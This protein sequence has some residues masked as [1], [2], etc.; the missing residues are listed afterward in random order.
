MRKDMKKISAIL[1]LLIGA[2][3]LSFAQ[4]DFLTTNEVDQVRDTQ[5]PNARL[6]LYVLFA[7]Q[8]MDQFQQLLKKDKKG[9]S[10]EARQLLED[11]A[12][13]IDE[14]DN[15]SDDALKRHV[16]IKEGLDAVAAA[17]KR[18]L[19]QLQKLEENQPADIGLYDT[20]FKEAIAATSDAL[21]LSQGDTRSRATELAEKEAKEKK[22]SKTIL[23]QEDGK[24]NP[25][26]VATNADGTP[27]DTKPKRKPPTLMRPGETPPTL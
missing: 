23:A 3:V 27:A 18:F 13:I 22:E 7:R 6:K 19:S 16:E 25:D 8:R 9:R 12:S 10:L 5:E 1:L 2:P 14:L 15:V 21:D 17:E 4:R 20:A 24:G 26:Q 11:Y